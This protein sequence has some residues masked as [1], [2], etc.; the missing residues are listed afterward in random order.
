MGD[1]VDSSTRTG[2][3]RAEFVRTHREV[4]F[5]I[6]RGD[7]EA[8]ATLSRHSLTVVYGQA[9]SPDDRRR[10]ELLDAAGRAE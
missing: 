4:Y 3:V 8:A 1:T 5:A 6:E 2:Q 10:L 7:A 9:L